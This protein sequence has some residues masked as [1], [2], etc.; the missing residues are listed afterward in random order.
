MT[1]SIPITQLN[2]WTSS[3]ADTPVSHSVLPGSAQ[4]AQITATCGL[5]L[6]DLYAPFSL[7][8][9][10]PRMLLGTSH[11]A[12]TRCYMTWKDSATPA[13]RLL[14]RLVPSMPHI[15]EIESGLW[16][17]PMAADGTHNHCLAPSVLAGK[18]TLTLTNQVRGAA[19]GLW[20]TP[21]AHNAKEGAYPA[22]Y[23]RNT[24][25]LAAEVG[26]KLN[27]IFVEW[28][29]GY[30]TGWTDLEDSATP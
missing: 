15:N 24:P 20:H 21:T 27:P 13:G 3:P 10:L 22:E 9:W 4:A 25:T 12:S 28:L 19:K 14:F 29:M 30:P 16:R 23:K 5:S 1:T 6:L 26:G 7:D 17:T 2:L 11:W 18:T 8:M